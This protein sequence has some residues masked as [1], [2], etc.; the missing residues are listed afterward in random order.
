[1]QEDAEQYVS[2]AK[3]SMQKS[4]DHLKQELSK[5]RAGK[6][7]PDMLSGISVPYYGNQTPLNQVANVT[8]SDSRTL[9]IQ[10][11]EKSMIAPIEK[12]IFEANLGLTPQNDGDLVRINIPALTEERRKQ[13]VKQAKNF[14]EETKVSLRSARRDA[15]EHLKKAIKEGYPEDAGKRL[16]DEVEQLTKS[17]TNKVDE[18]V[19]AKENDI[20]T[21]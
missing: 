21:L 5:I 17:Y 20:M 11:W 6:A 10:P 12:A 2:E 14:G 7:S 15:M 9:V 4:L 13:L 1:M 3:G 16:E 8:S 18:T 19:E